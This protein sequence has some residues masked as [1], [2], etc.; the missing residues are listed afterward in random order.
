[1]LVVNSRRKRVRERLVDQAE[2]GIAAITIPAGE[3]WRDAQ[4]L[5][6]AA[7]ESAAAVGAPEPSDADPITKRKPACPIAQGID[8]SNYLVARGDAWMLGEQVP[9][10][11]VQIGA[12][13]AA[14][15]DLDADLPGKRGWHPAF[16]APQRFILDRP[17]FMYGPGVHLAI[18][19]SRRSL[20]NRR[21]ADFLSDNQAQVDVFHS[22][23]RHDCS[24]N[25]IQL[26][27][28]GVAVVIGVIV[29]VLL[30][31]IPSL[32]DYPRGRHK[33]E[34]DTPAPTPLKHDDS[35]DLAA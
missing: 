7:T 33:D 2:V 4:V 6:A 28:T 19:T 31:I 13:D 23:A 21:D 26:L 29:I 15:V 20:G 11:Q 24:M 5:R 25:T 22:S 1:V 8:D 14:A 9:L 27:I 35:I 12:A 34:S 30:A 32:L 18:L 10:G 3:G 17:R 16:H